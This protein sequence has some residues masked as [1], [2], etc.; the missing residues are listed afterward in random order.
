MNLADY[1]N[2]RK[3]EKYKKVILN[4]PQ[5]KSVPGLTAHY[6]GS[7]VTVEAEVT[8]SGKMTVKESFILAEQIEETL[9]QECGVSDTKIIFYPNEI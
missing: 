6:N 2:P 3:E 5:I 7:L 4:N 9:K 8:V 1:F